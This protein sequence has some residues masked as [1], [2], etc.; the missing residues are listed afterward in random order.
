MSATLREVPR[1]AGGRHEF[2][3]GEATFYIRKFDAF[4][5]LRILGDLQKKLIGPI[6]SLWEGQAEAT[7]DTN[8]SNAKPSPEAKL[9]FT[10]GVEKISASLDGDTLV[11]LAKKLLNSE[12]IS[13]VIGN[14][15]PMKLDEGMLNRATDNLGDVVALLVEVVK[16]NYMELFIRGRTLIGQVQLP[17]ANQ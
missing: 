16:V 5:S 15:P 2:V 3:I 9:N 13:V 6:V 8:D 7:K 1:M 17:S 14:E 11:L 4:L 10:A 12:F